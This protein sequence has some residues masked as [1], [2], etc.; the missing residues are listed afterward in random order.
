[1]A[2][3]EARRNQRAGALIRHL[4]WP[5]GAITCPYCNG[6]HVGPK[7]ADHKQGCLRHT[8]HTC[9]RDFSDLTGTALHHSHLSLANWLRLLKSRAQRPDRQIQHIAASF[10][11]SRHAISRM[12]RAAAYCTLCHDIATYL[13]ANTAHHDRKQMLI[14][15]YISRIDPPLSPRNPAT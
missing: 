15:Y 4:R 2:I 14:A 6:H 11:L 1:M 3:S 8:C 9:R 13:C 7:G 12:I 10:N 5:N